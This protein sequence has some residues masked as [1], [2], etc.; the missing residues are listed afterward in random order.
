MM[1]SFKERVAFLDTLKKRWKMQKGYCSLFDKIRA[2]KFKKEKD[3]LKKEMK[4]IRRK[5]RRIQS[6]NLRPMSGSQ[7]ER[8]QEE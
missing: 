7:I 8:I 5:Q 4:K 1:P 2:E 6:A 3:D